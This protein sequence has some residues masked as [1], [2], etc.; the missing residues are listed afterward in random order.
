MPMSDREKIMTL[1]RFILESQR[2]HPEA[3]GVFTRLLNAIV[4][5]G[6]IISKYVNKAGLVNIIGLTEKMNIHGEFVSKLDEF[7]HKTLF[8]IIDY[9]NDVCLMASE[10]SKDIMKP[11]YVHPEGKYVVIYDPLDGSSNIP[12]NVSIGTIFSILKRVTPLHSQPSEEDTLQPGYRQEAAGYI[13]YGSSTMLVFTTGHGVNGFTLDPSIGEFVLSHRN[14]KMP[15]WS[16]YYS[17]NEG[18]Y[19]YWDDN[20]KNYIDFIKTPGTNPKRPYSL[21]YIGSLV[22]DF[23]RNL[24]EGGIFLYPADK[25]HPKGK[26]RLLYEAAPL[27][28]IAE[29]AGGAATDGNI[30]IME[31]VPTELHERTPL[32]I[33]CKKDVEIATAFI[34]GEMTKE[35]FKEKVE[36]K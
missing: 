25:K 14:I 18:Y 21:R 36:T 27:A 6:K 19:Y 22:A 9:G 31:K 35:D 20:V 16:K 26:L 24:L 2:E 32:I 11:V 23:H 13:L 33:G 10:E 29:Q 12:V 4:T 28:F 30:R 34:K 3:T 7:A 17:I 15:E 8:S 5:A 1:H